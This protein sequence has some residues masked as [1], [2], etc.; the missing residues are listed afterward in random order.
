MDDARTPEDRELREELSENVF[1]Y[2]KFSLY[3][4]F[5]AAF[6]YS[7]RFVGKNFVERHEK[8]K[9]RSREKC[10]ENDDLELFLF[11]HR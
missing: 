8:P 11:R 7:C 1:R 10:A 4:H 5:I 2:M 9:C 6:L 3:V